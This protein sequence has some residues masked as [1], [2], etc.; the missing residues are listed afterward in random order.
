MSF[1]VAQKQA[2]KEL[3]NIFYIANEVKNSDDI[4]LT[5][6]ND[7]A[8]VLLAISAILLHDKREAE[9]SEFIA[10]LSNDF[11]DDGAISDSDL[12][13]KIYLGQQNL[14]S[15]YQKI[16]PFLNEPLYT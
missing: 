5:D 15:I 1:P 11:A 9:F 12:M 3:L 13:G 7:D 14:N 16:A 2:H 8:A 4:G 6:G 10:K